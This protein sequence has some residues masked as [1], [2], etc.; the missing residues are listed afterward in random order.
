MLSTVIHLLGTFIKRLQV[1][2]IAKKR[3]AIEAEARFDTV[4]AFSRCFHDALDSEHSFL[5][6]KHYDYKIMQHLQ[7]LARFFG[8]IGL[9]L[10]MDKHLFQTLNKF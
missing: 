3:Y 7:K 8:F 10:T 4:N 2:A 9:T 1:I 5:L 6:Q